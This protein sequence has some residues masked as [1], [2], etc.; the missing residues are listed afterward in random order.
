MVFFFVFI[1]SVVVFCIFF[2]NDTAPT[3]I[4]TRSIVG[5]VRCVQETAHGPISAIMEHYADF[6]YYKGGV[7]YHHTGKYVTLHAIKCMGW[8]H[9][10]GMDYWL[11]ANSHGKGFGEDGYFKIRMGDCMIDLSLI[12]I[13]EPTRPLY[14][15][16]AVFC[17]KKKKVQNNTPQNQSINISNKDRN[18]YTAP[19]SD[20]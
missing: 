3:E 16:Y 11:C 18:V 7:Y 4:Y 14:I 13:S 1:V 17:L 10:D 9:E 6:D 20:S 15:S 19:V 12:H 8:G 2:F 5:S